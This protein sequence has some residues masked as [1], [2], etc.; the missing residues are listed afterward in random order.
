[1]RFSFPKANFL[2]Y[3]GKA[4]TYFLFLQNRMKECRVWDPGESA[5]L[6]WTQNSLSHC[7]ALARGSKVFISITRHFTKQFGGFQIIHKA[8]NMA[9]GH[10]SCLLICDELSIYE[11]LSH[12]WNGNSIRVLTDNMKRWILSV[13]Y[14]PWEIRK[15]LLLTISAICFLRLEPKGGNYICILPKLEFFPW[16]SL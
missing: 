5:E 9:L 15:L 16:S 12:C 14:N 10:C 4:C 6:S 1:M 11:R 8:N 3:L 2:R 13:R 7:H